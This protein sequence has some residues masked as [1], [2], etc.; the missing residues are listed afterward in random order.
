MEIAIVGLG[1]VLPA[2]NTVEEF[3]DN[4]L[5]Q[6]CAISSVPKDRWDSEVYYA[7]PRPSV[8][9]TCYSRIGAFIENFE[10][11]WKPLDWGLRI[12]PKVGKSIDIQHKYAIY[13]AKEALVD[14]DYLNRCRDK[15]CVTGVVMGVMSGSGNLAFQTATR[16][17][18]KEIL[19]LMAEISAFSSL[20]D[21]RK[22]KILQSLSIEFS[23]RFPMCTSNSHEGEFGNCTAARIANLFDFKGPNFSTDAACASSFAA[24]RTA[25]DLLLSGRCYAVVAGASEAQMD[26]HHYIKYAKLGALSSEGSFPFDERA[27][28]FVMGEGSVSFVLK[29][30][31][32]A[33][34]DGDKIYG[35]IR[36]LGASSDGHGRSMTSPTVTGQVLALKDAW[37]QAGVSPKD[38]LYVEAHGTGTTVGD[39]IEIQSVDA[40][41]RE[42]GL[43][44]NSVGIGSVKANIGHLRAAS[45]AAGLL[46]AVLML[47]KKRHLAMPNF[48]KASNALDLNNTPLYVLTTG[49]NA[50]LTQVCVNSFGFGGTNW[51]AVVTSP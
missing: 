39:S 32:N 17:Y 11:V 51:H 4:L 22:N 38:G 12:P 2:A 37:M 33:C 14:S 48:R 26:I 9:D 44:R 36:G 35:V 13:S 34:H 29:L 40:F 19:K 6:H 31:S 42:C 5:K 16:I 27:S 20:P 15:L 49:D 43:H 10:T 50:D 8:E 46:K 21:F 41:L 28:G 7:D 25:C 24:L 47:H 30:L 23:Q 18:L 45:G 3:Y 1:C